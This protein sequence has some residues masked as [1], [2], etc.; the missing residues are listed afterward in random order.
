[1]GKALP[2]P[3]SP[4]KP[5]HKKPNLPMNAA[6]AAA[7]M[8]AA[9][10]A[11]PVC[12]ICYEDL[13][14]LSDHQHLHCLPACGHVFHALWSGS[15]SSPSPQSLPFLATFLVPILRQW[16]RYGSR[17]GA[18]L[19]QWLE[20]CPG[21][22]TKKKLTCP[23]CKQPCGAAHPPTRLFFQSTGACPASQPCPS[24]QDSPGGAGADPEAL[25]AEVARL[26][27]KA[28]SLGKT[29][30]EQRD[31]IRRLNA[32]VVK[33]R[34]QAA[35]A[36]AMRDAAR[37]EKEC[38]QQLLNAKVEE[39]SRKTSE[40]GRLQEKSL[41]LAKE[42]AALKLSSDMNLQ[43]DE[44]LKLASLGN[45]GNLANAVD[46]LKRSLALRNKSYKELMVQCNVLGRSESRMQQKLEKAKEVL[47]KLKARVQ[48]LEKELEEKG[49]GFIRDLRSSK[50]F[51][52]DNA[53][54]GNTTAANGLP[55][56]SAGCR[57]KTIP[58]EVMHD[59]HNQ[60]SHLNRQK[61]ES[62]SDV[63]SKDKLENT[64]ADVI[65]LDA[66]DSVLRDEHK[67]DF[68]AR[69]FGDCD[70]TLDSRS[71]SSLYQH[72]N[73]NSTTFECKTTDVAK[74]TSLLRHTDVIGK[75]SFQEMKKLHILQEI[76]V[77]RSAQGTTSTW[78][79][80]TLT[81]DGISKQATRLAPGTGPQ[82]IHNLNSI[83]DDFRTPGTSGADGARKSIGKWCKGSATPGLTGVNANRGNLIAV[84]PDGRGGKVKVL[85]DL[86]GFQD[87]KSQ[88]LWPKAQKLGGKGGQSQIDH[89]FGKR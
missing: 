6:A 45:H 86:G 48:E 35:A 1:M 13:R 71:R 78:G 57:D 51:K 61:P 8:T 30:E 59:Q 81:I 67:M 32:E 23:M 55:N 16:L 9:A 42:L 47:K 77:L 65:D 36:E 11:W 7:A 39:L 38:V 22:K 84:G 29:L 28:V 62:E 83:S 33:W 3:S 40:C 20:Y 50:R 12:T 54:S 21:G 2:F 63:N 25:A 49:N 85:R 82:Q 14:P 79:E 10:A 41:A 68:S 76:P 60:E 17:F 44:I 43:E 24:S 19:E 26:E 56:L 69:P 80:E 70:N 27:Q 73:K 74:E 31:G 72:D 75:S 18:S 88:A 58:D 52:A 53:N 15:F 87:S 64:N 4:P 34:E 89:F 66:D 5:N 37:K 46:V